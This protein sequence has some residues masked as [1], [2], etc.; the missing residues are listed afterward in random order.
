[1]TVV[2]I[3]GWQPLVAC[4]GSGLPHI[5]QLKN[6]HP[7]SDWA[8]LASK[9]RETYGNANIFYVRYSST[10][11]PSAAGQYIAD[12]LERLNSGGEDTGPVVLVGH[13]MGG[14]VARYAANENRALTRIAQII[15]LGTPHNG[16]PVA[17]LKIPLFRPSDGLRSLGTNIV[18]DDI[19]LPSGAP[20]YAIRGDVPCSLSGPGNAGFSLQYSWL[21]LCA[22]DI[23]SDGIV[24]RYSALPP[25]AVDTFSVSP[26][27]HTE[28][29][30]NTQVMNQVV[31]WLAVPEL[32]TYRIHVTISPLIGGTVTGLAD[33][34]ASNAQVELTAIPSA[35]YHFV[36][37]TENGSTTSTNSFYTFV[38]TADRNL[39]AVFAPTIANSYTIAVSA[40]PL[41]SGIVTGGDTYPE[42]ASV[43]VTATPNNGFAFVRWVEVGS[44]VA[45]T[46]SFTFLATRNRTLIAEFSAESAIVVSP[47]S[48]T[49]DAFAGGPLPLPAAVRITSGRTSELTGVRS[50]VTY[51]GNDAGWGSFPHGL[52]SS[53]P[54]QDRTPTFFAVGVLGERV[55]TTPGTYTAFATVSSGDPADGSVQIPITYVVKPDPAPTVQSAILY[56]QLTDSSGII[57]ADGTLIN[58]SPYGEALLGTF[59][60]GEG[61]NVNDQSTTIVLSIRRSMVGSGFSCGYQVLMSAGES[62]VTNFTNTDFFQIPSDGDFHRIEMTLGN[63]WQR[64]LPP[65]TTFSIWLTGGGGPSGNCNAE[66]KSNSIG[67]FSGSITIR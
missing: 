22:A 55:T 51:N 59:T 39:I 62:F 10:A 25:E 32:S 49:F 23:E 47:M 42:G 35:G 29:T 14:L 53:I 13:S 45:T 4:T 19:P 11:E 34:Y 41:G 37:W 67:Q 16:T 5:I 31:K 33:S 50:A 7:E 58:P 26:S 28:L 63:T 27:N 57:T 17:D 40:S 48:V 30:S 56:Q 21:F 46:A 52:G 38:A 43:T 15:T 12:E 1:M 66:V 65:H 24:P 3:H 6:F 54:F 36:G 8:P 64:L 20:L 2:L 9:I 44:E 60:T 61:Y 18:N